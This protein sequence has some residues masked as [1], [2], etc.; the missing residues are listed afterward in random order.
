MNSFTAVACSCCLSL[1]HEKNPKQ[2][3]EALFQPAVKVN[4]YQ[5]ADLMTPETAA[6]TARGLG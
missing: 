3:Q 2:Q 6:G 5:H 1:A 4:S